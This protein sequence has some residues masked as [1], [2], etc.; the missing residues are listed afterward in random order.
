[1]TDES[2][3]PLSRRA[4]RAALQ[5]TPDW[6][7]DMPEGLTDEEKAAY[8]AEMAEA[9]RR[10]RTRKANRSRRTAE[11]PVDVITPKEPEPLTR[12]QEVLPGAGLEDLK[13]AEEAPDEDSDVEE[14]D[15]EE[16]TGDAD[17]EPSEE[18]EPIEGQQELI[19]VEDALRQRDQSK[20]EPDPITAAGLPAIDPELLAAQARL[21]D[22]TASITQRLHAGDTGQIP[23]ANLDDEL[24][25]D[26]APLEAL[27]SP[28]SQDVTALDPDR[29]YDTSALSQSAVMP[30]VEEAPSQEQED[31]PEQPDSTEAAAVEEAPAHQVDAQDSEA[32]ELPE[33][34]GAEHPVEAQ[35]AHGL[36]P[37]A[38]R[39]GFDLGLVSTPSLI[40]LGIGIL[41]LIVAI[42]MF[43]I[44]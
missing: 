8:E 36:D 14:V 43:I 5:Q 39:S 40:V 30:A 25:I 41:A 7:A 17:D 22:L 33:P 44:R 1:M 24:E 15:V 35:R 34:K 29:E 38:E 12:G 2:Q 20:A 19:S 26:L 18:S 28:D 9:A 6:L 32:E 42:I 21:A 3:Q 4:R 37:Q 16:A 11:Q 23:E 27:H 13:P 31:E 10:D